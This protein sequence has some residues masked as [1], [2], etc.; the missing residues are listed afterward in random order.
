MLRWKLLISKKISE[1]F[2]CIELLFSDSIQI[3]Y[4]HGSY[5]HIINIKGYK[6]CSYGQQ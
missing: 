3:N 5:Y 6:K 1:H 2:K 4:R